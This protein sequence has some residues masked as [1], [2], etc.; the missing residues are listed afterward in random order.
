MGGFRCVSDILSVGANSFVWLTDAADVGVSSSNLLF[1]FFLMKLLACLQG[2]SLLDLSCP[3]GP[4][5][6]SLPAKISMS[7]VTSSPNSQFPV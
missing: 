6:N 2:P 1:F 5:Y 4:M 7:S 3:G